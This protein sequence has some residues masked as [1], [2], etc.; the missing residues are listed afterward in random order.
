MFIKNYIFLNEC[1]F[2]HAR[3][4]LKSLRHTRHTHTP[5]YWIR[6]SKSNSRDQRARG[7][8][9]RKNR[10]GKRRRAKKKTERDP[11]LPPL[12]VLYPC[13]CVCVWWPGPKPH[14][15]H[16][17]ARGLSSRAETAGPRTRR[18]PSLSY[19]EGNGGAERQKE[20]ERD[21]RERKR[22]R[23]MNKDD[24][25]I[26]GVSKIREKEKIERGNVCGV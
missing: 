14:S 26:T 16:M 13:I 9:E 2:L 4:H 11:L 10:K 3:Q 18:S 25:K 20:G 5:R 6:V 7:D 22:M 23:K 24:K 19:D 15:L 1:L 21:E 8:K 12:Q 17:R